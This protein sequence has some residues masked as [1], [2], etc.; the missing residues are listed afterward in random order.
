MPDGRSF[1][2]STQKDN[3][4]NMWS[5]PIDGGEPKQLTKFPNIGHSF[6]LSPDGK[7]IVV[8]RGTSTSDVVL[9]SGFGK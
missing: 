4:V 9:I 3:A 6:D 5:Q 2:Y 7:Q 1:L 8:S